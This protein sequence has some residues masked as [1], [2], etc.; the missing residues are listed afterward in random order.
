MANEWVVEQV[1]TVVDQV[2]RGH[3]VAYGDIAGI[4]GVSPRQVGA[5][6]R[7]HGAFVT[8]WRVTSSYGDLPEHLLEIAT[9]RWREEGIARKPNCRGCRI[10]DHRAD[11]DQVRLDFEAAIADVETPAD[12]DRPDA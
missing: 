2:P 1:L 10:D 6:M 9:P 12:Q 3:V 8:W 5:V 11:L 4:V 7:S